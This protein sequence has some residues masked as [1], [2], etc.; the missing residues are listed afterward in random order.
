MAVGAEQPQ[1]FDS[2]VVRDA[3]DVIE[4]KHERLVEPVADAAALAAISPAKA[5]QALYDAGTVIDD[6]GALD[7]DLGIRERDL[8]RTKRDAWMIRGCLSLVPPRSVH[9][10]EIDS[11]K[12]EPLCEQ[13][14][15]AP[16]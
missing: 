2:V 6:G 5:E 10:G 3:I 1:I 14:M 16:F 7:E 12:G 11:Q 15:C 13:A 9:V 4:M 8:A